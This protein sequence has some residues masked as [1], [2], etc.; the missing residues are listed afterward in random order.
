MADTRSNVELAQAAGAGLRWLTYARV[1]IE[2]ALLGSMVWLARLI[3]PS[4]FGIFAVA[5]IVQELAVT[6]P[7]E[8][9]GS[10]LVQRDRV[11][12]AHLEGGML[13][14]LLVGLVLA[15]AT[16]LLAIAVVGPLFGP[17]TEQL[18]MLATA[19]YL[20]G[21]VYAIPVAT[22]RRRLDFRRLSYLDIALHV[23]RA[24][25]TIG[26]AL[27]GLDAEALVLGGLAGMATA[28][29]LAIA[30]APPP[31]PRWRPQAMRDLLPYGGPA[32]VACIAWTGFRNGDY[33]IVGAKLGT[34]QAGFYWRGYQLAVEYQRKVSVLMTEMAFP[35]LA[36]TR[37]EAQMHELRGR[38]VRLLAVVLFP[39]LVLLAVL[40]PELVPWAF[41]ERWKP[42]V[43][44]TQVLA[45]GGAAVVVTD[46]VGAALMAVGRSRALLGYGVAH[47]V[48]YAGTVLVVAS[49]GLAAVA[50]AASVVHTVFLVIAY[51]VLICDLRRAV[52]A[53]WADVAA[54]TV[55]SLAL[56]AAALAASAAAASLDLA[57]VV[58][59]A[60]VACAGAIAYLVALRTWFPAALHDL[61]AAIGRIVPVADARIR[62]RGA[63][64]AARR[65]LSSHLLDA[66]RG[67]ET[68]REFNLQ[69]VGLGARERVRYEP[70]R[71]LDLPRALRT[72]P[73]MPD[74]V[75]VDFGSGKGR[76]VCQAAEHPFARVIGVE[77]VDELT[78]VARSNV[79]AT[80][81][82]HRCR[83]V[84]LVTA[85]LLT[86]D[87]PDDATVG[88]M[89]NPLRG[90]MF[91][92]FLTNLIAALD[93]TP[94]PFRLL[95]ST[96]MEHDQIMRSGRFTLEREVPG[97]RPGA[98]DKLSIRIYRFLPTTA[99]PAGG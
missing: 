2:L 92:A 69:A 38:M 93:R 75:F 54:A 67:M 49:H 60:A 96:P 31:L 50:I 55:A 89:Y 28:L 68:S 32:A 7:M 63:Y 53:L 72:V 78:R 35:V 42:A 24:A 94:R 12:R 95:Y 70:S 59:L 5:V 46:A 77:L 86:Y 1:V 62:A 43:L 20:L 40:A 83:S 61:R 8:G 16:W 48:V 10:A 4:E 51:R 58:H 97:L 84:D 14:S 73:I 79:S 27:A 29:L 6:M 23:G 90:E 66:R 30:F 74:D 81:A 37:G 65:T 56:A 64:L 18:V 45:L 13:L 85:D 44:P 82:R 91:G 88:Y 33:A 41:G 25:A 87:L 26:L 21:S 34:A 36:R 57:V 19:W 39:L 76:V 99:P 15:T 80:L 9:V 11:A 22:M 47:F 98:R 52:A 17:R 3:P 71:W